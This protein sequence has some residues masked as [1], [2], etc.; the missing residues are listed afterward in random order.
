MSL[1]ALLAAAQADLPR[2]RAEPPALP[3][4]TPALPTIPTTSPY[5]VDTFLTD[6]TDPYGH[7]GSVVHPDVLDFGATKWNGRRY[8]MVATPF[9]GDQWQLE[10]P[11]IWASDNP[12][13]WTEISKNPVYPTPSYKWNSDTDLVHDPE[14]DELVM[15]YRDGY[16]NTLVSRSYD[17]TN[18]TARPGTQIT[19]PG[20]G[21]SEIVAPSVLR[22]G[23]EWWLW[24]IV[25]QNP[26]PHKMALW[27]ANK[28]EGTW[29]LASECSGLTPTITQIWHHNVLRTPSG[30]F[31]LLVTNDDPTGAG[32]AHESG[33]V[34][35]ASSVDGVTW[36]ANPTRVIATKAARPG[37]WDD[38]RLYRVAMTLH[39][40]GTHVRVWYCGQGTG[41]DS[42]RLGYTHIPLTE[43]P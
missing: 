2:Y 13:S 34:Y 8:W 43:W 14:T 30:K 33:A 26:G 31:I 17:G 10:N 19:L 3:A 37:K 36:A 25:L 29:T 4:T 7:G 27:K 32:V 38:H 18:W 39:E 11:S 15:F 24:G 16:F 42:W 12:L 1:L 35:A 23:T 40:N 5:N 28:P 9:Y 20:Y 6:L 22:V 21:S 41:S